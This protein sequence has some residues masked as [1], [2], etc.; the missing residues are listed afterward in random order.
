M[1]TQIKGSQYGNENYGTDGISSTGTLSVD[2]FAR[3]LAKLSH[4]LY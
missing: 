2:C 4:Q 1:E 3:R